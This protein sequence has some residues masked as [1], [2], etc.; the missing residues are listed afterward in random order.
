[1]AIAGADGTLARRMVGGPAER[2]VRA[3]S[4]TLN[5]VSCLSGFAGGRGAPLA[6]TVLANDVPDTGPAARA[7]R[8]LEDGV[9]EALVQYLEAGP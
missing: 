4:G 2:L 7:V 8:S 6:F 1:M 5:G 3:K 9:A